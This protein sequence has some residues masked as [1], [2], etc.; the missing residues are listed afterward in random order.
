MDILE[1]YDILNLKKE[2]EQKVTSAE[3]SLDFLNSVNHSLSH[4]AIVKSHN[5]KISKFPNFLISP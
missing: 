5:P 4:S 3:S 2:L 1:D